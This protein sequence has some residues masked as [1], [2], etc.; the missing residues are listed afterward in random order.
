MFENGTLRKFEGDSV[1]AQTFPQWRFTDM[2]DRPED[3]LDDRV[4]PDEMSMSE[5]HKRITVLL[6]NGEPAHALLTHWHFRIASALVNF[7]MAVMGAA[8]AV[9][10][11][12]TGLARNFGI[13]LLITFLYYVALRLGLVMGENGSLTPVLAAW[14]GNLLF[15]PL[16]FFL[17]WKAARV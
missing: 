11:V 15:A 2:K 10:A 3:L 9:N 16:G 7:F 12:R 17:W 14:F 13:A 6:R 1:L 8:L 4:Y 5:L